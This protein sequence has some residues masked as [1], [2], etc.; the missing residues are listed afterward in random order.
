M[1]KSALFKDKNL[2][3]Y[4]ISYCKKKIINILRSIFPE[5]V[6]LTKKKKSFLKSHNSSFWARE[7]EEVSFDS[8]FL[9]YYHTGRNFILTKWRHLCLMTL[10]LCVAIFSLC[11]MWFFL[12]GHL[13]AN[14]SSTPVPD[15]LM[16]K[17]RIQAEIGKIWKEM[18]QNVM[19]M[20][21]RVSTFLLEMMGIISLMLFRNRWNC[22]LLIF[23]SF[24]VH[25]STFFVFCS[26]VITIW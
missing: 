10:Q 22:I 5:R 18:S 2:L 3:K 8:K 13:K 6:F 19:K 21:S 26:W 1:Y 12:W 20:H 23:F 11:V 14:V 7:L 15:L 9:T 25:Y 17:S 24:L 16:L 4:T